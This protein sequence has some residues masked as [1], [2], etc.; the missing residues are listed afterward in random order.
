M[1]RVGKG[2]GGVDDLGEGP[3]GK[4]FTCDKELLEL[5]SDIKIV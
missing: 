3:Q 4:K 5:V 2:V 1:I